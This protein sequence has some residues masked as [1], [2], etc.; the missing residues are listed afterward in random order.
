MVSFSL[1]TIVN[2]F[3]R[4]CQDLEVVHTE[5]ISSASSLSSSTIFTGLDE[6]DVPESVSCSDAQVLYFS[7]V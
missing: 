7:W 4:Y 1:H 5:A 6:Q 3:E 2:T